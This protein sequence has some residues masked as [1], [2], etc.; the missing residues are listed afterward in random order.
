MEMGVPE[1]AMADPGDFGHD[2]LLHG[3]HLPPD[4]SRQKYQSMLSFLA[5]EF[6]ADVFGFG[7]A[8]LLARQ[9]GTNAEL[10][11]LEGKCEDGG[12]WWFRTDFGATPAYV[13][14]AKGC[15]QR[16]CLYLPEQAWVGLS[17]WQ[18]STDGEWLGRGVVESVSFPG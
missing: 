8:W 10:R 14:G 5:E 7:L 15:L 16:V 4:L 11:C 6:G 1:R 2:F 12:Q 9:V 18:T 13:L 3:E 17:Y